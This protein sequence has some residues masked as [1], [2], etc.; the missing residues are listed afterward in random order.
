MNLL[1]IIEEVRENAMCNY[2]DD[3]HLTNSDKGAEMIVFCDKT[4]SVRKINDFGRD[5]DEDMFIGLNKEG[6]IKYI[7]VIQNGAGPTKIVREQTI[8][9]KDEDIVSYL[10]SSSCTN[11]EFK[12]FMKKASKYFK[13]I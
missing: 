10:N 7:N 11:M 5:E 8:K 12:W 13:M 1:K 4:L 2:D 3:K 9:L 6:W